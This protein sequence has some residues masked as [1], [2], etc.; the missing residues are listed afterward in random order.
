MKN[1]KRFVLI[2][3]LSLKRKVESSFFDQTALWCSAF[4]MYEQQESHADENECV[5]T[6]WVG[7]F[8]NTRHGIYSFNVHTLL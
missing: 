1:I 6:C 4:N 8:V 3:S 2:A 7:V 5:N